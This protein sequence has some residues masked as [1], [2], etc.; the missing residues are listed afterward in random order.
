[1]IH[2]NQNYIPFFTITESH[3]KSRH[4][5]NEIA[6]QDYTPIRA[7]RPTVIKGGVIIY[8]HKD[9]VIDEQDTYTDTICQATMAFNAKINLVLVGIYRPPR[10]DHQSFTLCLQKIDK[11]INKHSNAD[12]HISGDFNLPFVNWNT[13]EPYPSSQILNSEKTCAQELMSLMDK[14]LLNQM[15]TE[16]TRKSKS[17]LDLVLTNNCHSIHSIEVDN[18]ELSDHDIVWCNLLYKDLIK[19]PAVNNPHVDSPLDT[20]NLNKADW[21]AIRNELSS[22]DWKN[23]LESKDA[24]ET[25]AQIYE[26]L[27]KTCTNHS[28]EHVNK[29]NNKLNIPPKRRSLLKTRKR[30]NAKINLCN[31]LKKPG[32]EDKLEKLKMKKASLEIQI[33]DSIREEAAK[34]ER[35]VIEKIKTNSRAFFTYAKKKSKTYTNIGPLL[36]SNNKLQ[37]DPSIMSNLLQEQYKKA[38][39]NPD[40]GTTDQPQPD[41]SNIPELDDI[42]ITEEDIVKAIDEVGLNSAPGPDKIPSKLLKECKQQIAPAL[43][44]L[45]RKSLDSGQIP[46]ELLKQTIIPIYKK[47]NKS[48]PSNYRPI[49]LTSHLIKVFERVLRD[50]ITQHIENNHL[51]TE[52]QHGF[53]L[54]RSPLTQL[55]H[56]IDS[57]IKILEDNG[58]ADILYLDLSKAF[59]KVNHNILLHKLTQMKITGK[60]NAWIKSFLTN[61]TQYVVVNG[62]KSDPAAVLSGVPQGTVLGPALFIIYMNNITEIIKS[63]IIKMFADDSKLI[64]SIKNV[65]DRNKMISDLTALLKWTESNSMMFNQEKFQLLQ[66]GSNNGLKLPYSLDELNIQNS[67]NVR[68]LGVYVSNNLSFKY[69]ITEMTKNATNFAAWLLRT[70]RTRDK[71]VMLLLLK[72]YIIPR[73]EYASPVWN[74]HKIN[75]IQQIEAVQRTFT[76]KIEHMDELNYWERLSQLKLFSIQRRRERFIIIHTH[77]I[78]KKLAPNDVNLQFHEHIRLGTQCRRLPLKSKIASVKTLRD[79]FFS[80]VAPKLYN[81]VPKVIKSANNISSFKRKLDIFLMQIPDSPPIS[82]YKRANTN[83]LTE[84]VGSIQQAKRSMVSTD[85]MNGTHEIQRLQYKVVE[86]LEVLDGC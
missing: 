74:P 86:A 63:T 6:I 58:N 70:F 40:S 15:V 7:D 61:R 47:D 36:D 18:T 45:W 82:G 9:I 3:L 10:A 13:K 30:T 2:T 59:D 49:S 21:D 22:V 11:F 28:P 4:F 32:Y 54:N 71:D 56:H 64:C 62:H 60:V 73:L 84:W 51:I 38:F 14:H 67:T 42:D 77:K 29:S 34:K 41:T 69:H 81:L 57:I 16:P 35:E 17:I 43:V 33:R 68:D 85:E 26:T 65:E 20:L 52:H 8:T 76:A 75:E 39:S 23:M 80:Q 79:N 19:I 48:L 50:K 83:S 53:R 25:H 5:D 46:S 44:I 31:Y 66:I 55:L 24:E 27:I 78:Y 37:C 72:T 12:I 1:M